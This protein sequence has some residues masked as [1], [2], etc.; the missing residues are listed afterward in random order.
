[1]YAYAA[2]N[3]VHYID[4]DGNFLIKTNKN[5]ETIA[6]YNKKF[7]YVNQNIALAQA[8]DGRLYPA[9]VPIITI[10]LSTNLNK[11]IDSV[12]KERE[13]PS[14]FVKT[15]ILA[16]CEKL[17]NDIYKINISVIE[18]LQTKDGPIETINESETV[19]YALANEVG[20]TQFNSKA[21]PK[22]VNNIANQVLS[23]TGKGVEVDEK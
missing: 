22:K 3:P 1:M 20:I 21:D 5:S 19:A 8:N 10:R 4:P 7:L 17:D 18:I 16:T 15:K 12:K 2:N 23:Y 11:A 9:F 13:N 14:I 6:L